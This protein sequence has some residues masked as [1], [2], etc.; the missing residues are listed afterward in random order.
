M[1]YY[2][3]ENG[4]QKN[5]SQ[6]YFQANKEKLQKRSREYYRNLSEAEKIKKRN[7]T[8]IRTKNMSDAHREKT[9]CT[10]NYYYKRKRCSI[11]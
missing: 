5:K 7:Y 8:N 1:K 4:R 10:Q 11:A 3:Q 2:F 6:N 9:E